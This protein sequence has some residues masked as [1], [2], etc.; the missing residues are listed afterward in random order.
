MFSLKGESLLKYLIAGTPQGGILSPL[1][2]NLVID[3]LLRRLDSLNLSSSEGMCQG[4]ADDIM[5]LRTSFS[6][7]DARADMQSVI[8]EVGSWCAQHNLSLSSA[9]SSLVLFTWKRKNVSITPLTISGHTD[10]IPFTSDV[11]YLGVILNRKLNWGS[12]VKASVSKATKAAFTAQRVI[13]NNWG[14]NRKRSIWIYKAIVVPTIAYGCHLWKFQGK[15]CHSKQLAKLD[16]TATKL[17]SRGPKFI[18]HKTSSLVSGVTPLADKL[19]QRAFGTLLRLEVGKS[20]SSE[21]CSRVKY[22]TQS[23][24]FR[25]KAGEIIPAGTELDLSP[26]ER[27]Q[28]PK[29]TTIIA[30]EEMITQLRNNQLE[31]TRDYSHCCFT[32]GSKMGGCTGAGI[33]VFI[34][35]SIAPIHT[36]S[37]RLE[38]YNSVFQ[39]ELAAI[40]MACEFITKHLTPLD[41]VAILSDSRAAINSLT[42]VL[43][44]SKSVSRTRYHLDQVASLGIKTSL[45]WVKA[46]VGIVGN[47]LAD[48]A[49]KG[50][51]TSTSRLSLPIPS[52]HISSLL[53]NA[54]IDKSVLA[55]FDNTANPLRHLNSHLANSQFRPFFGNLSKGESRALAAFLDNKAPLNYFV[56]KLD[57]TTS[58]TCD[59]CYCGTQTNGHIIQMSPALAHT[60]MECFGEPFPSSSQVTDLPPKSL[61]K[62][63]KC[64]GIFDGFFKSD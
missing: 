50:G 37:S 33:V 48:K 13:G 30:D 38:S 63:L 15:Y 52:S 2:W 25:K 8:D 53:A 31:A 56:A 22:Q 7:D 58:E 55:F 62:F 47:E 46:H 16:G 18:S 64:C 43:S 39:A 54:S 27:L 49:A 59:L 17:I 35:H 1:L 3:S 19:E 34:Q 5:A 4:Y 20:L 51:T 45:V 9:K 32:D 61:V 24:L 10:P 11:K 42:A 6:L 57:A 29:F 44:N 12:Q 26:P 40:S 41:T 60:R 14:V 21:T 28:S 23:Q 36:N